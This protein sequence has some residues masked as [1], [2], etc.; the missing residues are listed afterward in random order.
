MFENISS[1]L[2][3]CAYFFA[4]GIIMGLFYE[5]LRFFRMILRH[6]TVAVCIED[7]LY[8]S[9]CA[10]ISFIIALSVGIGYMRIYYIV[11]EAMGAAIYFLTVGR[12]FNSILRRISGVM[13]RCVRT[14]AKIIWHCI[15]KL[16]VPIAKIIR[17]IFVQIAENARK[18]VFYSKMHLKKLNV[19]EYNNK[20]QSI[21]GGEPVGVVKAKIRKKE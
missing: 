9:I 4:A 20:V 16:F 13:K 2:Q 18:S 21:D 12:L 19:I 17:L 11:F 10:F 15:G 3:Q 1:T 14:I 7:A 6:N 8:L 5:A